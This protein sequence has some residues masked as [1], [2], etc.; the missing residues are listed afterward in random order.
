MREWRNLT[1]E[2]REA[3]RDKV[4]GHF[5]RR[6]KMNACLTATLELLKGN[7]FAQAK[8][9]KLAWGNFLINTPEEIAAYCIEAAKNASE[10]AAPGGD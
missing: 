4:P 9:W 2:Q 8:A 10:L 6:E 5:N 7:Q 3:E 1:L